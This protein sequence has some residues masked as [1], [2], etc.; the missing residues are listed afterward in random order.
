MSHFANRAFWKR[1]R[2]LPRQIRDLADKNHLLLVEDQR[3]PSLQFKRVGRYW[4]ARVGSN[5]RALGVDVDEGI[6]WIWIGTHDEYKKLI[7]S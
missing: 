3:H 6:L 4:S 2:E 7:Q 1:Y 5:Y